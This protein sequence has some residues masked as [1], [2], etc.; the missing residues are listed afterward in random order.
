VAEPARLVG[1]SLAGRYDV[2]AVLGEGGMGAVYRAHDRELDEI[3]ALKLIRSEL[4]DD[5]EVVE[6]F[7]R[8]VKLARRVTHANVART[9]ELG[10][11]EAL[12]FCTMELLEGESLAAYLRRHGK[13]AAG[14]A[15]VVA[16]AVLDGLVAA[17]AAGVIHRDIKPENVMMTSSG[18]IVV[19]DFGIA[20]LSGDRNA[21]GTPPYMAP[22]QMRGEA[23]TPAADVYAV[24]VVLYEMVTGVRAF[25]GNAAEI[26]DAKQTIAHLVVPP[27]SDVPDELRAVIAQATARDLASRIPTAAAL[28][29]ALAPWSTGGSRVAV[30]VP[31]SGDAAELSVIV[32]HPPRGTGDRMYI[33]EA[34]HAELLQ[35]LAR[36]PRIRVHTRDA[37]NAALR[38]ELEASDD[39]AVT[40][41]SRL[42]ARAPLEVDRVAI[43]AETFAAAIVAAL[44]PRAEPP[45][46]LERLLRARSSGQEGITRMASGVEL[47]EEAAQIAPESPQIAAALAIAKLQRVFFASNADRAM[48]DRA[49]ALVGVALAAGPELV[50][51]H[52]AAGLLELHTGEPSKAAAHFRLAIARGPYSAAAHE[53]LGRML[54]EAGYLDAG[55]ARL[56]D[57]LAISPQAMSARWEIARARALEQHWQDYDHLVATQEGKDTLLSRIRFM[58]WRGDLALVREVRAEYLANPVFEAG[59]FDGIF[60]V[61]CDGAWA[62][63]RDR[64]IAIACDDSR[65][66]RRRGSVMAQIVAEAAGIAGDGAVCEQMIDRAIGQGL[67]DLHWLDRCP[68]VAVV[69]TRERFPALRAKVKERADAILDALYGDHSVRAYEETLAVHTP[70]DTVATIAGG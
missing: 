68:V 4:A 7:R 27:D 37:E 43:V 9:F 17:H 19:A 56:E 30:T 36:T 10:R 15:A 12:M 69:R 67:F 5:P 53:H 62:S 57:A 28:R 22:E 8:E 60:A 2:L 39:L 41:G 31:A 58:P 52:L 32:V 65:L 3:V 46:A 61:M 47:L 13:L 34:I 48:L 66:S 1:R 40:V 29:R 38:V 33:A 25:A 55:F 35:R 50:E 6:R 45:E 42:L 49:I 59:F 16:T 63:E 64:L 26:F 51:T 21:D 54:C 11:A 18:R 24:G 70:R 20:A 14:E 44:S 23:P